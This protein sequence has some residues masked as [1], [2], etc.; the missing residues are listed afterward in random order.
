MT[1]IIGVI[2]L[3][4]LALTPLV[5]FGWLIAT[6]MRKHTGSVWRFTGKL[7]LW[8]IFLVLC[9][10]LCLLVLCIRRWGW[11]SGTLRAVGSAVLWLLLIA[12]G[13]M[14]ALPGTVYE[15]NRL[16]DYRIVTGNFNNNIY[17]RIRYNIINII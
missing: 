10:P 13:L 9:L 2:L 11:L 15:T 12:G 1:E 5:I 7:I 8:A 14:L 3:L 16:A 4:I 6:E 17:I